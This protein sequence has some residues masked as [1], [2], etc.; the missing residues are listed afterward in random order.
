MVEFSKQ[1]KDLITISLL[2]LAFF[3][4]CASLYVSLR[5][6]LLDRV[7]LKISANLVREPMWNKLERIDV[8]ILNIGRRNAVLEGLLLHYGMGNSRHD[9]DDKGITL[10]EKDR[11]KLSVL[12]HDLVWVSSEGEASDLTDITVLDIEGK[13]FKIPN[14]RNLVERFLKG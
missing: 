11:V 3:I 12:Y 14:S 13:E 5:N 9:Y 2:V 1:Y 10:K 7:K 4:S 6:A 8:V